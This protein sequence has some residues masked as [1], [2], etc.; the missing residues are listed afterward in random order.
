[1][2]KPPRICDDCCHRTTLYFC[3]R[4]GGQTI[5][6]ETADEPTGGAPGEEEADNDE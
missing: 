5:E 1:M 2:N 4:C 3:S 6:D